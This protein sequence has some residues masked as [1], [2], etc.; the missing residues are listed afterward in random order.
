MNLRNTGG[1][2]PLLIIKKFKE[3]MPREIVFAV[4]GICLAQGGNVLEKMADQKKSKEKPRQGKL[5]EV[6]R[7]KVT[8]LLSR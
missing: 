4:I 3:E 8:F 1:A 2:R 7:E 5:V 6:W